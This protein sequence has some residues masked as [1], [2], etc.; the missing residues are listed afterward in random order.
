MYVF[1]HGVGVVHRDLKAENVFF[2]T[3]TQIKLGDFG[4]STLTTPTKH[5]ETFCGSPPYAAPEL[6]QSES[7]IGSC[8]DIWAMGVML[9]FMMSGNM[10]F[11]GESVHE[12][13]QKVVVGTYHM[14]GNISK[15]CQALIAGML[16]YKAKNRYNMEQ[17]ANSEWVLADNGEYRIQS[18]EGGGATVPA[19]QSKVLQN[20]YQQNRED[21]DKTVLQAMKE[22]GVP[23]QDIGDQLTN[24]PRH[25]A[26]GIYRI[27]LHR[28]LTNEKEG[29][30]KGGTGDNGEGESGRQGSMK[31]TGW[32]FNK[33]LLWNTCPISQ[34]KHKSKFCTIL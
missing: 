34:Q 28:K 15:P 22:F 8:V 26:A 32:S 6:F 21:L 12:I 9:Y 7:Y 23:S 25:P 2:S 17:I 20:M 11:R 5:L 33:M 19:S 4:F 13:K 29:S 30:D 18:R 14:P 24:E 1:Q 31:V 3:P 27:L 16:E 10:P